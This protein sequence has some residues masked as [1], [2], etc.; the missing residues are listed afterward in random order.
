[1]GQWLVEY[2]RHMKKMAAGWISQDGEYDLIKER[3]RLAAMQ[4]DNAALD[5][6]RKR[7]ELIPAVAI[8]AALNYLSATVRGKLL[9]LP[10][11]FRSLAPASP[12]QIE[13][14]DGL[15]RE[16][17]TE[18]SHERFPPVVREL[19]RQYFSGLQTA[20]QTNGQPVG[21]PVPDAQSG[22]QR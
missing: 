11:R 6:A 13:I 19:A 2:G 5:A 17:L 15:V 1:M 16:I 4:A 7:E 22:V 8:E 3:A 21:G 14:L 12:R 18:L 20:A 10:P 9:S